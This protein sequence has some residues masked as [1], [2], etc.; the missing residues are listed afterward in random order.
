MFKK[1]TRLAAIG[2]A[3]AAAVVTGGR[4]DT[5][6]RRGR[7][8]RRPR[9]HM[10]TDGWLRCRPQSRHASGSPRLGPGPHLLNR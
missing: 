8:L 1:M 10:R 5:G 6:G 4:W 7:R 3:L 9:Q 2:T